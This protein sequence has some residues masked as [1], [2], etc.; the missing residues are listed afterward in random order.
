MVTI[1]LF[2]VS[3]LLT[4][5]P[6]VAFDREGRVRPFG[7]GKKHATVFPLWLLILGCAVV[8]YLIVFVLAQQE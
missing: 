5:K 7:T 4:W 6:S 2:L 8:A 3:G 1:Y